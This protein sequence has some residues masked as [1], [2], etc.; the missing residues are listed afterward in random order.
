MTHSILK[1]A[2]YV[3]RIVRIETRIISDF[4]FCLYLQSD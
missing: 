1:T 3:W 4:Y 2:I